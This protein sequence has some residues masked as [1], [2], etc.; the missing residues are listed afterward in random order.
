ME[1]YM[2]FLKNTLSQVPPYSVFLWP[3][4]RC[5]GQ[6]ADN[7][8]LARQLANPIASLINVPFQ[9][10]YDQGLGPNNGQKA[11]VACNRLP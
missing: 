5:R 10:N 6:A 3:I 1:L 9:F 11:F 4:C 7:A 8:E 2:R